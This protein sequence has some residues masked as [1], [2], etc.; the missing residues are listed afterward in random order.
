MLRFR[1]G[2]SGTLPTS[3]IA[4]ISTSDVDSLAELHGHLPRLPDL[5]GSLVVD[6]GVSL[7]DELER[8]AEEPFEVVAAEGDARGPPAQ[9]RH[10]L[11]DPRDELRLLCLGVGVVEA[12]K[13]FAGSGWEGRRGVTSRCGRRRRGS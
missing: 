3:E 7:S 6:V 10:V 5:R 11:L 2:D 8:A 12:E 4:P 13:R 9:P 1:H